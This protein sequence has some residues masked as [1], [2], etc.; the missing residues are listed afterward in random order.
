M[1]MT[2]EEIVRRRSLTLW[3]QLATEPFDVSSDDDRCQM[4][5][6][7]VAIE[8]AALDRFGDQEQYANG[9]QPS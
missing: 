9:A 4:E 8:S 6:A 1:D 3:R 5:I 7:S 2:L